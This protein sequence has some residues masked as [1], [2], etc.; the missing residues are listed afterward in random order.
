MGRVS[1]SPGDMSMQASK[2]GEGG[3]TKDL[4]KQRE[5]SELG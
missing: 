2:E 4:T 3:I 5:G 1:I